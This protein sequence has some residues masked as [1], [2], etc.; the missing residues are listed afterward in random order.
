MNAVDA[1]RPIYFYLISH[2]T[3]IH[4]TFTTPVDGQMRGRKD[5]AGFRPISS[6]SCALV[7]LRV[8]YGRD[9]SAARTLHI[10]LWQECLNVYI[11]YTS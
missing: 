8:A 7:D 6:L 2:V 11:I 3:T 5:Q 4:I 9:I 1:L 10:R